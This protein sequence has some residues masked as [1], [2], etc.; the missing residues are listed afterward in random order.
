[1]NV[2]LGRDDPKALTVLTS[3]TGD[4]RPGIVDPWTG[5]RSLPLCS[6]L[7]TGRTRTAGLDLQHSV[8]WPGHHN[9][10]PE[11]RHLFGWRY[12]AHKVGQGTRTRRKQKCWWYGEVREDEL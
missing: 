1:V 4:A 3:T 6:S 5:V 12:A 8:R 10:V 11:E 7:S 2:L 9:R